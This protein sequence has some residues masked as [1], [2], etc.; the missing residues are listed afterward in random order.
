LYW[1]TNNIYPP[2]LDC[3]QLFG[4]YLEPYA[5]DL[6][7]EG[8][9][10][11][12]VELGVIKPPILTSWDI[13][14]NDRPEALYGFYKFFPVNGDQFSIDVKLY[15]NIALVGSGQLFSTELISVYTEFI[16]DIEYAFPDTPSIAVIS[17]TTDSSDLD[18]NLHVGSTW[19]I[20]EL[21]FGDALGSQSDINAQ[22]VK[23]KLE[24]NYPNPFNP[25]TIIKYTIPKKTYVTLKVFDVLGNKI[26]LLVNEEKSFGEYMVQFDANSI[27]GGLSSG[28]YF[29]QLQGNMREREGKFIET[30][31]MLLLM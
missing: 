23:F 20:D 13:I 28:V 19:L 31:K 11:S 10:D 12:C 25:T 15:K 4:N 26:A 18:N 14:I 9:V 30:K 2:P 5:G 24:Q 17:F 22:P 6:C 29:Y 1:T 8:V 21:T 3:R 27:Q 16:V 7:T